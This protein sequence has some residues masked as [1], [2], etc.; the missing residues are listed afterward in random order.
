M[1][2]ASEPIH[3]VFDSLIS[4]LQDVDPTS[5]SIP[6]VFGFLDFQT[7]G[8]WALSLSQFLLFWDFWIFGIQE[9]WT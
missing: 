6:F 1:G 7:P 2:T 4:I 5:Q 3:F 9:Q 8:T